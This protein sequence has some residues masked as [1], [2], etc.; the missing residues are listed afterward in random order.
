MF[1]K[2]DNPNNISNLP[3][4]S[5]EAAIF[6]PPYAEAHNQKGLGVGDNDRSDLRDYS[7]LKT[8][9]KGQIGNLPY[10]DVDAVITSPPYENAVT[11]GPGGIDWSKGTRGKAEGNKPR[12]RSKEP[13]YHHL[14]GMALDWGYSRDQGN[15]G[16]LKSENYLEAMLQVYLECHKVLKEKGLMVLVVKN[17]IRDKKIIRLDLDTIKL[18]KQAGFKLKETLKRKLT[19]QSFWRTIYHNKYPDVEKIEFEDVLIFERAGQ[20]ALE[21]E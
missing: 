20:M 12:D 14:P 10:G 1:T 3:Y 9:T 15:I 17:F 6:S 7:Y 21:F 2:I 19:Q 16:N 4:G 18:C 13:A 8:E 5:I 11:G